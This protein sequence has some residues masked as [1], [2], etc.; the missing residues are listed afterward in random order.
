MKR[1]RKRSRGKSRVDEKSF[2]Y[3][4]LQRD[5]RG[6][7]VYLSVAPLLEVSDD[8]I[9]TLRRE[10]RREGATVL[11]KYNMPDATKL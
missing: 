11:Q 1:R 8:L 2:I 6:V 4:T 9:V 3:S 7:V 10:K 5:E